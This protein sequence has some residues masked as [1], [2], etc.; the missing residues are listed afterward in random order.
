[1]EALK[2]R[3]PNKV[4]TKGFECKI[5]T[6]DFGESTRQ[7]WLSSGSTAAFSQS[8]LCLFKELLLLSDNAKVEIFVLGFSPT[9]S[10]CKILARLIFSRKLRKLFC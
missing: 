1:M 9:L 6:A 5:S 2:G 3:M 8:L 10:N 4:E 7:F